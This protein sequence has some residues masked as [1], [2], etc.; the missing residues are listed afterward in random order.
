MENGDYIKR[1]DAIKALCRGEGCGN[2]CRNNIERLPSVK[3]Q[4]QVVVNMTLDEDALKRI[5]VK[6]IE[7]NDFVKVVRCKDCKHQEKFLFDDSKLVCWVHDT[8]IVVS[9][10]DFCSY[11]EN[12][13]EQEESEII[14]A[15]R[16]EE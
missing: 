11:G 7:E 15:R 12:A 3:E 9:P 14:N 1:E 8:D 10:T 13:D 6:I 16:G 4:G 5:A 2:I